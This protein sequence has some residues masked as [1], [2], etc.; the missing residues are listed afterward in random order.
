MTVLILLDLGMLIFQILTGQRIV[1]PLGLMHF[2]IP[3]FVFAR[4]IEPRP[5]AWPQVLLTTLAATIILG[6]V[7]GIA[8]SVGPQGLDAWS[9]A[10]VQLVVLI[11]AA[12]VWFDRRIRREPIWRR[13]PTRLTLG[14]AVFVSLGIAFGVV[15]VGIATRAARDAQSSAFVQ[16]WSVPDAASG[17]IL[18]VRNESGMDL[19]CEITIDRPDRSA[20]QVHVGVVG[21]SLSWAAPLP[22]AGGTGQGPWDISL[23]CEGPDGSTF[24]RQLTIIPSA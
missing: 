4:A 9:V 15:G 16:F 1:A 23:R 19:R 12:V 8:S 21:N 14:S 18:G 7:T 10:C 17:D 2:V 3:G 20:L 13:S 5:L 22:R 11:A 24:E 6:V